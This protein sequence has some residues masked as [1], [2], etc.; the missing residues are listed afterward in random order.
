[1]NPMKRVWIIDRQHWPRALLRGE[2]LEDGLDVIG[3]AS[4]EDALAELDLDATP[5]PDLIVLEL[6]GL[7]DEEDE[8]L[9]RLARS[10]L[11]IILLGGAVEL[12]KKA[13]GDGKWAAIF[14][15]PFTLGQVVQ[16]VNELL[17]ISSKL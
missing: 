15:R 16:A 1:M 4:L 14:K 9:A 6:K 2:L 8:N 3:F 11:P 7:E 13:V 10:G 12:S 5:R 17:N